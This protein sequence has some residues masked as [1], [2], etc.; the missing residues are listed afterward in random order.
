MKFM[1]E[2]DQEEDDMFEDF[3]NTDSKYNEVQVIYSDEYDE[4]E[5]KIE[6]E[7]IE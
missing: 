4:E 3:T 5:T 2:N 1:D 6:A 7:T